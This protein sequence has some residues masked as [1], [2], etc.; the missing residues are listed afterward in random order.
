MAFNFSNARYWLGWSAGVLAAG[1]FLTDCVGGPTEHVHG[2]LVGRRYQAAYNTLSCTGKP[3]S[4]HTVHHPAQYWLYVRSWEGQASV[5]TNAATYYTIHEGQ[6]LT[7]TR[8][9]T[10]WSNYTWGNSYRSE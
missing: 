9:R 4:C 2:T 7:Y 1:L 8:E 5:R 3:I 6:D 10:R